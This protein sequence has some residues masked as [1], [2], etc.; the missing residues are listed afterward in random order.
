MS[1]REG[2]EY[3]YSTRAAPVRPTAT[4]AWAGLDAE[5]GAGGDHRC[6]AGVDGGDDLGAVDPLEIDGGDAEVG[7]PQLAL[8]DVERY[9]LVGQLDGVGVAELVGSE[10]APHT[11]LGG[12]AP[13][14]GA[15]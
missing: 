4:S 11:G 12:D 5:S 6:L 7:V 1:E 15:G 8:N 14:L 3:S 10:A 13:Q 9:A 2:Q